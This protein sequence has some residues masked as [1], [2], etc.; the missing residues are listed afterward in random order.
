MSQK[1]RELPLWVRI[2]LSA[3]WTYYTVFYEIFGLIL[4]YMTYE[5][6]RVGTVFLMLLPILLIA[7]I[8]LPKKKQFFFSL[9]GLFAALVVGA[10]IF[11]GIFAYNESLIVNTAPAIDVEQYLPFDSDS[12]ITKFRSETLNFKENP[13]VID[14]AAALFP[15][16]SAFVHATYPE[17]TVLGE[18]VFQY[19]NTPRGY[20]ALAKKETDLF[21]GVYSSEEQLAYAAE[22]D[23]HFTFTPIGY[24]A[25]VFFIHKDNPVDSLTSDQIRAI[26]AGEITN[27]KEVGG[28]DEE[29]VA[30]QRNEGSGSQSMLLR[31]MGENEVMKAPSRNTIG[32]MGEII[33]QVSD[34]KSTTAS[35]GFSFRFY[36]EGIIKNPDI[37]MISIDGVY[38]T[39]DNVREERYPIRT[40]FYA[41]T[42]K[43]NTNP[44]TDVLIY[45]I[46]SDEGQRIIEETGYVGVRNKK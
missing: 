15:V 26:Y 45:W 18:G 40:P 3:L 36:V 10:S 9:C 2:M 12:K 37:K 6:A 13:P 35:I 44:N 16:Y 41:V 14:G 23:T 4:F 27:W 11:F 25:F 39:A 30:Y 38:P 29:I 43:E 17:D 19:N 28:K 24:D 34:Y 42:Y 31:F 7:L 33:E 5:G 32:G 1:V 46:L 8:W 21:I 22:N 20:R